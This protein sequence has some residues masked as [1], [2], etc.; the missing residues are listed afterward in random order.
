ML[1]EAIELTIPVDDSPNRKVHAALITMNAGLVHLYAACMCGYIE[2]GLPELVR[3][4]LGKR[5]KKTKKTKKSGACVHTHSLIR[6]QCVSLSTRP[7]L[8]KTAK[9]IM[10]F[11]LGI[12]VGWMWKLVAVFAQDVL[13]SRGV[14]LLYGER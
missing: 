14:A 11:P 12:L 5:L 9:A 2:R 13:V 4:A 1:D 6:L 10:R 8:G 3:V 7:R